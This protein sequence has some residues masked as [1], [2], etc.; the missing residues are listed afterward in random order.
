M[1]RSSRTTTAGDPLLPGG[2]YM[3]C[4]TRVLDTGSRGH[5]PGLSSLNDAHR[6]LSRKDSD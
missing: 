2:T 4:A 6:D 3:Q 5:L 1:V